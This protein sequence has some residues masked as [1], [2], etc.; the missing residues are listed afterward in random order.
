MASR[1]R[2]ARVKGAQFERD[3]AKRLTELTDGTYQFKRGLGQS[4][5]AL[6][7]GADVQCEDLDEIIHIE[8]KRHKRSPIKPALQQ[9]I[10][11][12][13]K[14]API[15]IT[16]DDRQPELVTMKLEDWEPMFLAW[17]EANR[18]SK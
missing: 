7:E 13:G 16:K 5:G 1:G 17:V 9:A 12:C 6:L 14:A 4:R 3:I 2:G 8:C 11:D 10:R 18:F 15:F